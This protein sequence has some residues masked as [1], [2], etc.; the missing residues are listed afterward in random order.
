MHQ[1]KIKSLKQVISEIEKNLTKSK[2]GLTDLE[3]QFKE[4]VDELKKNNEK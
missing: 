3:F 4:L 2:K 1:N